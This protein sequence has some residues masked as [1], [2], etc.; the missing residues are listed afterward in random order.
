MFRHDIKRRAAGRCR[1]D[2]KEDTNDLVRLVNREERPFMVPKSRRYVWKGRKQTVRTDRR[3]EEGSTVCICG[4]SGVGMY[5][6][7]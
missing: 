6:W 5:G 7:R 2:D 3:A 4:S 1:R